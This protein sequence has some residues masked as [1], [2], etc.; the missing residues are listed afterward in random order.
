MI[1]YFTIGKIPTLPPRITVINEIA[2]HSVIIFIDF[3]EAIGYL[4]NQ[5]TGNNGK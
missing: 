3:P 5:G 2:T 4:N 1:H